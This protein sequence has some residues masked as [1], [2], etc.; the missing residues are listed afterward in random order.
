MPGALPNSW[1]MTSSSKYG[2]SGGEDSMGHAP[3]G[4]RGLINAKAD[5]QGADGEQSF[6]RGTGGRRHGD[7]VR[8][9][10]R[11][12]GGARARAR[13]RVPGE[14]DRPDEG[15]GYFRAGHSRALR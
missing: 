15:H 1:P 10:R 11:A 13:E 3:P 8:R 2:P 7:G 4:G 5:P 9:P 14:T 6:R 12:T